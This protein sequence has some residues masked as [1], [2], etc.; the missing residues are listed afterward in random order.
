LP[1]TPE[2]RRAIS[3]AFTDTM[4]RLHTLDYEAV[5][6]GDLGKPEGFVKRQVEGWEGRWARAKTRDIP[7]L[8]DLIGWFKDKLPESRH[9]ALIHNDFKLDNVML[10]RE[11]PS[12]LT[13]IFDWEMCTLGDPLLD[14]GTTLAY[15][16]HVAMPSQDGRRIVPTQMEGFYSRQELLDH[17]A[18]KTGFDIGPIGYHEAF[19]LFKNAVV[20][21]QIY[22]RFVRGQT[23]DKRFA[24]LGYLVEPMIRKAAQ[25]AE[26]SRL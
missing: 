12:R 5:G 17:Y 21:E 20:L 3:R 8:D 24:A 7:G 1:D 2:L 23:Q 10:D 18:A 4:A 9:A 14:L 11:D 25:L 22:V 6:L 16:T 19:S 26:E 15:W 13:S